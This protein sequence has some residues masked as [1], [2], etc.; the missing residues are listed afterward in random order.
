MKTKFGKKLLALFLA[1]V[2]ALTAFSGA[3]SAF[4]A[5]SDPKYHDEAL[6]ANALAWVELT[7]EQTCAALLDYVDDILYDLKMPVSLSKNL[8]VVSVNLNG[9][10]DSVSGLLDIVDQLKPTVDQANGLGK[11]LKNITLSPL[12]GLSYT[13]VDGGYP[14]C[15]K[16]YRA[17]N[18]AKSIV[19]AI[20]NVLYNNVSNW[21]G[22][23]AII[24]QVLRGTLSLPLNLNIYSILNNAAKLGMKDGY[25][26][27]L[28]YNIIVK[29]LT[30][31]TTWY[32]SDEATKMYNNEAGYD[33]D[34]ML[35]RSLQDELLKKINVNVT[36]ADG[37]SSQSRFAAGQ[38][39]PGLCYTPDGNVYLFQYDS[40]GD[41]ADDANLTLTPGT[42]LFKFSYD[43]L[44]IA[45]KTVL[46]PTLRLLNNA[47]ADYDWDYVQWFLGQGKTWDYS[48]PANNYSDANVKAWAKEYKLD[49]DQVK[50]NLT[51]DRSVVANA[52]NNWRDIDST[53]LFNKLRRS[54]LMVYY[55]KGETGPLNTNLKCTGTSNLDNFMA[56]DYGNYDNI[57]AGLNDFLIAAVKDF[58]PDYSGASSLQKINTNDAKTIG[59]TLVSNALKVIQYVGDATDKNI[60]SSF[61]Q[62]NGESAALSESNLEGAMIPLL[63]ACLQNNIKDL[64][65]IHLDKWDKCDDAEGVAGI[66][67]QEHL[68][69]ILPQNDYSQ[70]VTVGSDGY[71]D[72]TMESI[73]A[74]CRDAVGYVMMQYVPITDKKGSAWSIYNVKGVE[75]Y[76]QQVAAGTD[77]FSIL[78]SV[79]AYYANDKGVAPLLGCSDNSGNSL[80]TLDNTLWKNIDIIANKLLPVIGELQFGSA[81]KR[82]Q[83]DSYALIMNDVVT[84]ALNIASTHEVDGEQLG[85]VTNFVYRLATIINAPSIATKGV[86]LT[87]YD[88]LKELLNGLLNA[89][90]KNQPLYGKNIIPDATGENANKPFH[91]LVQSSVIAGTSSDAS[92]F[93]V[94]S[95]A[96]VNLV[97]FAGVFTTYP[98]TVWKGAMFAVQAVANFVNGFL[99]QLQSYKVGNLDSKLATNATTG[100]TA[101]SELQNT[102]N[103][104]N[105]G[106]G[107]NRFTI[108]TDGSTERL[109]RSWIKIKSVQADKG[110]W[111]FTGDT[112]ATLDPEARGSIGVKGSLSAS[113]LGSANATTVTFT[114]T[115]QIVN[116]SGQAYSSEYAK[117]FSRTMNYY[118]S[119]EKD[120][121]SQT[122]NSSTTGFVDNITAANKKGATSTSTNFINGNAR[123]GDY[124]VVPN[125]IAVSTAAPEAAVNST[126]YMV[127]NVGTNMRFEAYIT[128]GGQ[129]YVAVACNPATGDLVNTDWY[130]YYQY[131]YT[132]QKLEDGT[133]IKNIVYDENG[134]PKGAWV[135]AADKLLSRAD[136]VNLVA[137]DNT[138]PECR[139]HVV[140]S[141]DAITT[142]GLNGFTPATILADRNNDGSYNCVYVSTNGSGDYSSA[143]NKGNKASASASTGCQGLVFS[144]NPG[145][146]PATGKMN[147]IEWDKQNSVKQGRSDVKFRVVTNKGFD[148]VTKLI[149]SDLS[150]VS[151][152]EA[153]YNTGAAFL[154]DYS[155][156]DVKPSQHYDYYRE[157]VMQALATTATVLTADNAGKL[158][159][160]KANFAK[161]SNTTNVVGELAYAPATADVMS[162]ANFAGLKASAIVKD[163]VY[164]LTHYTDANG[165]EVYA[166]PIYGNTKITDSNVSATA[167]TV[168]VM[169]NGSATDLT[170]YTVKS[171]G[172]KVVK[173]E[174]AW[175]LVN[176]AAY[177]TEWKDAGSGT[178]PYFEA[179]YLTTTTTQLKN[180]AGN[181]LYNAVEYTH[182][183]A[184]NKAVT[185]SDEWV[186]MYAN[187]ENKIVPGAT[188]R[189]TVAAVNDKV[190]YAREILD[191]G[192][193]VGAA[194]DVYNDVYVLRNGL[195][196]VN[197]DVVKYEQMAT[198][199]RDA[200]SLIN[201][202][203]YRNYTYTDQSG[204]TVNAFG[205]VDSKKDDALAAYNAQNGTHLTYRDLVATVD[206]A[207][208]VVT[209]TASN[210]A[211]IEA[212]RNFNDYMLKVLER[213]YV[214]NQLEKEIRCAAAGKNSTGDASLSISDIDVDSTNYTYSVGSNT[215][216]AASNPDGVTYSDASWQA[217]ITALDDAV[218]VV[219]FQSGLYKHGSLA[220][221]VP[222]DKEGYTLSISN[223]FSIRQKLMLAENGL[224]EASAEPPVVETGHSV[225]A[226]I[227]AM[228][229]PA[230]AAGKY[231]V[232]GA[233][234][235]IEANGKTITA[236]TDDAGKF[237]L[238]N[239]PDGTY[240]ATV[241]YKYGFDRT[242]TITV[243]GAD[244]NSATMV[245]IVACNWSYDGTINASD[246][247]VYLK[248]V[249]A[250]AGTAS[251]DVG[252]DI[253]RNGTVNFSDKLIYLK[254]VGA[255]S[256]TTT[257]ADVTVK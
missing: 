30:E 108:L 86:D 176:D 170:V 255:R 90:S 63:I 150:D 35:F 246:K 102:I 78:N 243:K 157:A 240:T 101:G 45:W 164:Y 56:N 34:T 198:A 182:N 162:A 228:S 173:V 217:F 37:T 91:T 93:G 23:H 204:E 52:H 4:A 123:K 146:M 100:Y 248:A 218:D 31:S 43:A 222:E 55:F 8:V 73:Y 152:S 19:K 165:E 72:V 96:I 76:E 238:T 87:V 104:E 22:G 131:E 25:E 27:N 84:G 67:L 94:L 1:A 115:Y 158:G 232:T 180:S 153:L 160:Q 201:I 40:N 66:I 191:A 71:Y 105:L 199:G 256:N 159:S 144:F 50:A 98:D 242:F 113:D 14:A 184:N 13:K 136:A 120:L 139:Q 82:G 194:Q 175:H 147:F 116:E 142:S 126:A 140:C 89:R 207:K 18:S 195:E 205:T 154:N 214:P 9:T 241:T 219:N 99:P 169:V 44:G 80:I 7:D 12:A 61:Y 109:G 118:V 141:Y 156:A 122:Y 226:Y 106:K 167:E 245:G 6:K 213:G 225:S 42:S 251:Y 174:G 68:A 203:L 197:F 117:D 163:G 172:V 183:D 47:I 171:T 151:T 58:F 134:N 97:Q 54:P 179:P 65:P 36:Y 161:T 2:M 130:D 138:V 29:L 83:C 168:S 28:V 233:V 75:T 166:N 32:T 206:F 244:V 247:S 149:V 235:S 128:V 20:L 46:Q 145:S 17:N 60:L 26:K 196:S 59:K 103:L 48:N 192:L 190:T 177:E 220:P 41:G 135:T 70:F 121:Y 223:L 88:V 53:Q 212:R 208:S 15:G 202:D 127:K 155:S 57:L 74:M 110:T 250:K 92:N 112:S 187:T 227:G 181:L 49:L 237:T 193:N 62:K 11:D 230:D 137:T 114:V 77:I 125:N 257:Y 178:A 124:I 51:F 185:A 81:A 231:A 148:L 5:S 188:T 253:D 189:G 236:T 254:F 234:V 239:V 33:L 79:I 39:D 132:V 216:T 249:G 186:V 211:L 3:F 69:Y 107:I 143:I 252:L 111:T 210:F 215:Y 24:N 200:E 119:A 64:K 133:E 16:D 224:T 221:Y 129:E 229:A 209:S 10:L 21:D 95:S 85:G 38:K